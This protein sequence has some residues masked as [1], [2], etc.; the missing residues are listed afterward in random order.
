VKKI[1][2]SIL[3]ADF[4]RLSEE[5]RAVEDAGA[6]LIH[7]DVM[8]GH[9]VPNITIGPLV[10]EGLRRLTPLPLDVHLM[11]EKP[12]RYI[13]A[14]AQGGSTWITFHAEVCSR[15]KQMVKRARNLNVRPGVVLNP[16]TPLKRLY[17]ILDEIDLV[18]LMSVHPGFGGQSFIPATL[19]KIERLRRIV[20]QNHYALEIEVDG[21]IKV[22]N[23][24]EVSRAGGDIFVLGTGIFKTKDYAETIRKLR[25][26]IAP[27]PFPLPLP[28]GRQAL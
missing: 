15:P 4:S 16:S 6:D 5:V 19:K 20:D 28:T 7:V 1:A 27:H 21:G 23:I 10:V 17:P 2:P 14:F 12:E 25:Q 13:E 18:L 22:E 3:S 9:F 11:I 8:D 26:E 24:G